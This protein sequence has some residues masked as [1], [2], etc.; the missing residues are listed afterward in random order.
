VIGLALL[1]AA[2]PAIWAPAP[3]SSPMF[4]SHAAFD[5]MTGD[6]YFVR[7]SPEFRGWRILVSRCGASGWDAP[8]DTPFAGDGVEADLA[9]ADGGR[10]AWFISTRTGDGVRGRG[11]DIWTVARGPDGRWGAPARLPE[12]LNSAGNEWFPRLGGDGWLYF[13]SDRP[14]GLGRTD[15]W[16]GRQAADGR[17]TVENA[18]AALNGPGDEYEPL[19]SPD[20]ARMLLMTTDGYFESRRTA[21]GWTP[22]VR[23]EPEI[24][25]NGSEIGALFSPSGRAFLFARNV[26]AEKSGEFFLAGDS[27]PGWPPTCPRGETP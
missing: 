2:A 18:G 3:V 15:I 13:G 23:L 10:T 5:P 9:F 24:N 26:G 8:V 20:G 21:T 4:E 11:L 16:R 27:E 14:G 19:I 17:W 6:F 12:P 22:R 1:I 25:A 7:S